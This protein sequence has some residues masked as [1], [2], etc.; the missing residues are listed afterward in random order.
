MERRPAD[1]LLRHRED[2]LEIAA[3]YGARNVR[4][5]GSMARGDAGPGSDLDLLVE[6]E[7]GR[8][9][10]DHVALKQ[11]LEDLLGIKVD[12]VN[13]TALYHAIRDRVLSEAVPV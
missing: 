4:A 10:M 5:F 1:I 3:R 7:H 2:I 13:E 9:L 6:F 11:D 12:V 8:S